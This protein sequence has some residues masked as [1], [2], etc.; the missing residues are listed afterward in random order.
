[1]IAGYITDKIKS[2]FIGKIVCSIS[3]TEDNRIF[4]MI[5][6]NIFNHKVSSDVTTSIMNRLVNI[7]DKIKQ[8]SDDEGYIFNK[9]VHY[10]KFNMFLY[11]SDEKLFTLSNNYS[12]IDIDTKVFKHCQYYIRFTLQYD[13]IK[14]E[15]E[16]DAKSGN[17]NNNNIQMKLKLF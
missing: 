16:K 12:S 13:C 1:M 7:Q 8:S 17:N 9:Y 5:K 2:R 3:L 14:E 15:K 10:D 4:Q 11:Y 6:E